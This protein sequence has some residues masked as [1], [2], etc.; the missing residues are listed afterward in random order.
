MGG[1]AQGLFLVLYLGIWRE[2]GSGLESP[3]MTTCRTNSFL[4]CCS[5]VLVHYLIDLLRF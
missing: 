2:E 3:G 5:I 4:V 1:G